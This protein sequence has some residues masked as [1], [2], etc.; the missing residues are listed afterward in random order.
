MTQWM[1]VGL[2]AA[3]V[4]LGWGGAACSSAGPGG[5]QGGGVD[6]PVQEGSD[7]GGGGGSDSGNGGGQVDSGSPTPTPTPTC[8]NPGGT[9]SE[10]TQC[11]QSGTGISSGAV[12]ISN[13]DECHATCTA[14]SQCESGCCAAIE[15]ESYGVCAAATECAAPTCVAPGAS[16]S[17]TSQ[18]C[19]TGSTVGP[20]GSTC[21]SNDDECHSI[22]HS[23]SDCESGCCA[24][25][26]GES[27]G[28]CAAATDC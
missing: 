13:D 17:A 8:V 22:C 27:W 28:V 24:Q 10:T 7:A 6:E 16:C 15:G 5:G 21:I 3:A 4:V 25:V 18:C 2:V 11:C 12:C 19:Q 26:T 1:S 14:D 20:Y 23:G 9:C